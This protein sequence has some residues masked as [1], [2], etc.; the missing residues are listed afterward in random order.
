MYRNITYFNYFLMFCGFFNWYLGE[1]PFDHVSRLMGI[2]YFQ[3]VFPKYLF[4]RSPAMHYNALHFTLW[5]L[6]SRK[7]FVPGNGNF[8]KSVREFPGNLLYKKSKTSHY[9]EKMYFFDE[10]QWLSTWI[11]STLG[12]QIF[13]NFLGISDREFQGNRPTSRTSLYIITVV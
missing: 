1:S 7:I 5:R 10:I 3:R 4:L 12:N 9:W 8:P 11:L 13:G 6:I 2:R